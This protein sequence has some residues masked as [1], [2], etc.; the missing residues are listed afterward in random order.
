M[1][2]TLTDS[3][4]PS[5]S[6]RALEPRHLEEMGI[7][8]ESRPAGEP[9]LKKANR[10]ESRRG[11]RA[12]EPFARARERMVSART[13]GPSRLLSWILHPD[14]RVPLTLVQEEPRHLMRDGWRTWLS[15]R[16]L[17]HR[18]LG[19]ADRESV[20]WNPILDAV[21]GRVEDRT[22]AGSAHSPQLFIRVG[23]QVDFGPF[24]H[25]APD[26]PSKERTPEVRSW[27]ERFL[28]GG[29]ASTGTL[30]QRFRSDLLH[31]A[32]ALGLRLLDGVEG[33]VDEL[34]A[35][36]PRLPSLVWTLL[37]RQSASGGREGAS[38]PERGA[39]F[40][41]LSRG[42]AHTPGFFL[43][44]ATGS[45]ASLGDELEHLEAQA[46]RIR[47]ALSV[48]L[49]DAL[50]SHGASGSRN[51]EDDHLRGHRRLDVLS[52]IARCYE[53]SVALRRAIRDH[54]DRERLLSSGESIEALRTPP[55]HGSPLLMEGVLDSDIVARVVQRAGE[56]GK[57]SFEE[58][59][60]PRAA[61]VFARIVGLLGRDVGADALCSILDARSQAGQGGASLERIHWL[62]VE[63]P[64]RSG[65]LVLEVLR[66]NRDDTMRAFVARD[67][68][69]FEHAALLDH[70]LRCKSERVH[71]ALVNQLGELG[72][73]PEMELR[74]LRGV[75]GKNPGVALDLIE[76]APS[77]RERLT[78]ED[79]ARLLSSEVPEVR[80]RAVTLVGSLPS[81]SASPSG[82]RTNTRCVTG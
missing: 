5:F 34:E 64:G 78:P 63:H 44:P 16:I 8:L 43:P 28:G 37:G 61:N 71:Q 59:L 10:L 45:L 21:A 26:I 54:P 52:H 51:S 11:A 53:R 24:R 62:I 39:L 38:G 20:L 67:P 82:P 14:E 56:V 80:E 29:G 76:R 75:I 22:T 58:A 77:L 2:K 9:L 70:L 30:D 73:P 72:E 69:A 36:A 57:A 74:V 68:L 79:I 25:V 47:D 13:V 55:T 19:E 41:V 42:G 33:E 27:L 60:A 48:V 7:R 1:S 32:E 40:H 50:A 4:A 35:L 6:R 12:F 3:H 15:Y 31:R 23:G 17:L 66:R 81:S 49:P 65:D 18:G 46:P